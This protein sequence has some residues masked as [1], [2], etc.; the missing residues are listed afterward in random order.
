MVQATA[1]VLN[2]EDTRFWI[3]LLLSYDLVFT[4]ACLLLFETVLDAE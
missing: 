1:N 4:S 2:G 3:A